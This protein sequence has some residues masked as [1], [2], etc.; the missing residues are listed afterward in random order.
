MGNSDLK[1][2]E[3]SHRYRLLP[4]LSPG[5]YNHQLLD[6]NP[7]DKISLEHQTQDWKGA[8]GLRLKKSMADSCIKS[9][10]VSIRR[11][12]PTEWLNASSEQQD[13]TNVFEVSCTLLF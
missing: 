5:R 10:P 6:F 13:Q 4:S 1:H 2:T 11:G 7:G 12:T 8:T 9:R 3:K